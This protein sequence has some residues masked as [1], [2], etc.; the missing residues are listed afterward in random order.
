MF[1]FSIYNTL[2]LARITSMELPED[3]N[4]A[5][6]VVVC[7]LSAMPLTGLICVP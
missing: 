4:H 1:T 2:R 3:P 7:L 6:W 5:M